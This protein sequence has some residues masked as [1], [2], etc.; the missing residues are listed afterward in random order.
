[1]GYIPV[2]DAYEEYLV[3]AAAENCEDAYVTKLMLRV[4]KM[5]ERSI[6]ESNLCEYK[7]T[8]YGV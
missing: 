3:E 1:M 4:V 6:N 5:N 8:Q 7:S 2:G